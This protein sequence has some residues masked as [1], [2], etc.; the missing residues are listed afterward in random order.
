[1]SLTGHGHACATPS[2]WTI[3][4]R[5][6]WLFRLTRLAC[7]D[8]TL[9]DTAC[10]S[11]SFDFGCLHDGMSA[12]QRLQHLVYKGVTAQLT[13]SISL[14]PHL[15]SLEVCAPTWWEAPPAAV[16]PAALQTSILTLDI[17]DAD[18]ARCSELLLL[19]RLCYST[20][21]SSSG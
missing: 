10:G 15:T 13:N 21:A 12:L 20:S 11:N 8:I 17:L 9:F 14:L 18:A 16:L 2:K 4:F 3:L 6:L 1:M 19:E 5:S 7:L